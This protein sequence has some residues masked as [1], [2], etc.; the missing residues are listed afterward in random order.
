MNENYFG[1][2]NGDFDFL[3]QGFIGDSKEISN[4]QRQ[5]FVELFDFSIPS[6]EKRK[7]IQ[8]SPAQNERAAIRDSE[9]EP[10]PPGIGIAGENSK[11]VLESSLLAE[12]IN[13]Y[14]NNDYAGSLVLLNTVTHLNSENIEARSYRQLIMKK[15]GRDYAKHCRP[16]NLLTK[17]CSCIKLDT[18]SVLF[19][20]CRNSLL[21]KSVQKF[22]ASGC[23]AWHLFKCSVKQSL[24]F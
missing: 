3:S 8:F 7:A 13:R 16:K 19:R 21:M 15:T 24:G 2:K 23:R 6:R 4:T 5:S 12:G 10:P 18:S 17:L 1:I 22:F 20:F 9:I 14:Q 11:A